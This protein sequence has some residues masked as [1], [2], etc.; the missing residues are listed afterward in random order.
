M[1]RAP[2]VLLPLLALLSCEVPQGSTWYTRP[3]GT[4]S[5]GAAGTA[6]AAPSTVLFEEVPA[7]GGG[8]EYLFRTNDPKYLAPGGSADWKVVDAAVSSEASAAVSRRLGSGTA[9]QG[10]LFAARNK[11]GRSYFLAVLINTRQQYTIEKYLAGEKTVIQGWR[12][13]GLLK[14]GYGVK[15]TIRAVAASNGNISIY[16]NG[17]LAD[18]FRDTPSGGIPALS[19]GGYGYIVE[20]AP[21]EKLP[22]SFVEVAFSE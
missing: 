5:A 22:A 19:T 21:D 6:G 3:D 17:S 1:R 13:S 15:N 16:F 4:D 10:I 11:G 7:A 18:T 14:A 12:H 8:T 20:I 9:G 2:L